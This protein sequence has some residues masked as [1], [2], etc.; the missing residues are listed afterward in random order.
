[1][2][3][4]YHKQK[5]HGASLPASTPSPAGSDPKGQALLEDCKQG[6]GKFLNP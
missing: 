1:M 6:D 4:I 3:L 5:P 2:A